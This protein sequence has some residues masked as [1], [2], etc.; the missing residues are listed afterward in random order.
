M[1]EDGIVDVGVGVKCRGGAVFWLLD[2]SVEH[3]ICT[4]AEGLVQVG[5]FI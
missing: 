3:I 1:W 5:V 2:W 4:G